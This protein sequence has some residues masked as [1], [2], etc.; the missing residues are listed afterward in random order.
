LATLSA[1]NDEDYNIISLCQIS[2]SSDRNGDGIENL[3]K[4]ATKGWES[5]LEESVPFI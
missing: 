4:S 1:T 5:N 3:R 2:A